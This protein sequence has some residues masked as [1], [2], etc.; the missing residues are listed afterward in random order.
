MTTKT[1]RATRGRNTGRATAERRAAKR[2]A[3]RAAGASARAGGKRAAAAPKCPYS[4]RA[5][6]TAWWRWAWQTP[7]AT[8]W[9]DGAL[10]VIARRAALED[11]L[12]VL[13]GDDISVADV[14][15]LDSEHQ[16]AR[17][18]DWLIGRLR[19]IAGGRIALMKEMRELDTQLGLGPKAMKGLGWKADEERA[20]RLDE[21]AQ[22]RADRPAG[23]TGAAAPART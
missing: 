7:Q 3:P 8:R 4:L 13:D 21:L 23:S 5:A 18:L 19:A 17:E 16:M 9:D 1:A 20:D 22:R 11:D 14:L 2:T 15:G 6:G 10:Y 12:A